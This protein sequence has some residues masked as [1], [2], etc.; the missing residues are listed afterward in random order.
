M[1]AHL[2]QAVCQHSL[3]SEYGVRTD[4]AGNI[5]YNYPNSVVDGSGTLGVDYIGSNGQ[6]AAGGNF[7]VS[8]DA[9]PTMSGGNVMGESTYKP[10]TA[11]NIAR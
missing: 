5:Q 1:K 10:N 7:N 8:S 4:S 9:P 11:D 6:S 3:R 2:Q